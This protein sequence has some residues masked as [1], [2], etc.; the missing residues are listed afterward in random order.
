MHKVTAHKRLLEG[1]LRTARKL[2]TVNQLWREANGQ[3]ANK[4]TIIG[5]YD[6]QF[7]DQISYLVSIKLQNHSLPQGQKLRPTRCREV[8]TPRPRI[9]FFFG[10]CLVIDGWQR[11]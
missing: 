8:Y 5:D 4:I 7:R 3:M 10:Y 2:Q 9:F 11:K 1:R 6:S